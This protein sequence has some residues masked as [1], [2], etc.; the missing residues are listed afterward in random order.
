[1]LRR[2]A[3]LSILL[4]LVAPGVWA[5]EPAAASEEP[6]VGPTVEEVLAHHAA[7]RGGL[8]A[9]KAIDS[10]R[11][12]GTLV[13]Q[14]FEMPVVM[15]RK[16]PNLYRVE[17]NVQGATMLRVYDGEMAWGTSPMT[18]VVKPEPLAQSEA[19]Q[20]ARQ[21]DLD[22]I[23]IQPGRKGHRVE[24][25]G[26]E[27]LGDEEVYRLDVTLADGSERTSFV[28]AEDYL[29]RKQSAE[30]EIQGTPVEAEIVFEDYREVSGVLIP[31][32]QVTV[33]PMGEFGLTFDAIEVPAELDRELFLMP[34]QE[35][36]PSLT[37]IEIL[38]RHRAA[39]LPPGSAEVKTVEA[40]GTVVFQG[41]EVPMTMR[42]ER[43]RSFRVDIDLQGLEMIQAY[44]GEVAWQ[45]SPMQGVTEPE[46]LAEDARAA[47]STFSDFV[48]GL[49]ARAEAEGAAIELVGTADIARDETYHLE[50]RLGDST[51]HVYLGGED[52]LERQISFDTT[53]MGQ[54]GTLDARLGDYETVSGLVVPKRIELLM[55]GAARGEMRIETVTPGVEIDSSIFSMPPKPEPEPATTGTEPTEGEQR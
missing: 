52:F 38:E 11:Y 46:A 44:D 10:L 9:I 40:T 54:S 36:D 33:T 26:K 2:L 7:A 32:R 42:F 8:E 6:P 51:R 48:W 45:V 14:G 1:M 15:L 17:M 39:R 27:M 23:L 47:V 43:P 37:Q 34:G 49:L 22:G 25:A 19:Q 29:E 24:L 12:T 28:G 21:A 20:V 18:G 16:R 5:Q 30:V 13:A 41:F 4:A 35:A 53:L 55:G 31:F 3:V 50:V